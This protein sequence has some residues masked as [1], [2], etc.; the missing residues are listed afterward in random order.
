[1]IDCSVRRKDAENVEA[2]ALELDPEAFITAE[3][4]IPRRS[5]IWRS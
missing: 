2:L 5:G 4:V 1:M 3:E